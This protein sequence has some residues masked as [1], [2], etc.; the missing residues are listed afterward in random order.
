MKK[1]ISTQET[2]NAPKDQGKEDGTKKLPPNPAM[3]DKVSFTFSWIAIIIRGIVGTCVSVFVYTQAQRIESE[4]MMGRFILLA[5]AE[6]DAMQED[7]KFFIKDLES[8]GYFFSLGSEGETQVFSAFIEG[9]MRETPFIEAMRWISLI[10]PKIQGLSSLELSAYEKALETKKM[11]SAIL[12]VPTKNGAPPRSVLS[13]FVPIFKGSKISGTMQ[14]LLDLGNLVKSNILQSNAQASNI[15]I[16]EEASKGDLLYF[17]DAEPL[18]PKPLSTSQEEILKNYYSTVHTLKAADL[19]LNIVF[20]ATKEYT[21][22]TWQAAIAAGIGMFITTF[23]VVTAWVLLEIEKRQFTNVLHEE[24][25]QELEV[26]IDQ[27]ES[28]KNRLVAQENLASLGG[29][30]AGIAHEIKNPLN[31]IN[32]FSLLSLELVTQLDEYVQKNKGTIRE[33]ELDELQ[34][35]VETLKNNINTIHDQGKKA[36]N[37]IQRMLAHSRGKPGDWMI[38]DIHKLLDEYISFSYHGMRAKNPNFTVKIEKDFD[39]TVKTVEVVANDMSRVFLNLLNNAFQAVDERKKISGSDYL[40][41]VTVKTKN[42]GNYLRVRIRD[43]GIGITEENKAKIFTPFFTTKPPGIGTG[44]GLSLS[45]NIIVREHGG[46]L[47][48][49]S[50]ENE[51]T[52]FII[53]IPLQPKKEIEAVRT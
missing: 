35:A 24:H 36:D 10:S 12:K 1:A 27:L 5:N 49:D 14:G 18:N 7:L 42:I 28:T 8:A 21:E 31:F 39:P 4:D 11:T 30:T 20:L 22:H 3:K 33:A 15:Y 23:I 40:P 52:E 37:T 25:V 17:Y 34:T 50:Q 41:Q 47:T 19:T 16:Y 46:A 29:L 6:V 9:R 44:L 26:T 45:Y 51:Y 43:N 32:N 48:F 53:T 2:S 13:L 38:T